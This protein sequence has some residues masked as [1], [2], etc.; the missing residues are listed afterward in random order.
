[1]KE[2]R[3]QHD[4]REERRRR[5]R[6]FADLPPT[7][8]HSDPQS[9]EV[10]TGW[11]IAVLG[12]WCWI[13]GWFGAF[14]PNLA[15]F[16]GYEWM[17]AALLC[18]YGVRHAMGAHSHSLHKRAWRAFAAATV[19]FYFSVLLVSNQGWRVAGFPALVLAAIVQ[20]WVF[21]R[22]RRVIT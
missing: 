17:A 22:L 11:Y 19:F 2:D 9:V 13:A 21:L 6:R 5:I 20:G 4:R 14:L 12:L 7:L 8:F 1:M 3:R 16:H 15:N 10:V 18:P